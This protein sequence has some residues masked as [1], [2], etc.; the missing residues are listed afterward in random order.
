MLLK[1]W[2][3]GVWEEGWG[4]GKRLGGC[5]GR[6]G[7]AWALG[8]THG[9]SGSSALTRACQLGATQ[10]ASL[11]GATRSANRGC[12]QSRPCHV[13]PIRENALRSNAL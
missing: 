4:C 11:Q 9:A 2:G 5:G 7:G 3:G 1:F 10:S 12:V 13:S 8:A 6:G